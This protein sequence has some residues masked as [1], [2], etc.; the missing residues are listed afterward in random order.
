MERINKIAYFLHRIP[1]INYCLVFIATQNVY[2]S[3][4][5]IFS[6][7]QKLS[8]V[9]SAEVHRLLDRPLKVCALQETKSDFLK[10]AY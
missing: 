1:L 9:N 2:Q 5:V 10:A 6:E 8:Y 3:P 4:T 7:F